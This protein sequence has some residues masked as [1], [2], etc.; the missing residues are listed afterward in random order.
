MGKQRSKKPTGRTIKLPRA[1]I[2][3]QLEAH[4][5][6]IA[7]SCRAYDA[8]FKDEAKR[9]AVSL[10]AICHETARSHSLLVQLDLI[11][12]MMFPNTATPVISWAEPGNP[13]KSVAPWGL[14][15]VGVKIVVG[16]GVEYEP[17]LG[18][19]SPPRI[20]PPVPFTSW[21]NNPVMRGGDVTWSRETLVLALANKD[22]GA[23]VDPE[24]D[25]DYYRLSRLNLL[26]V[27]Y[28]EAR[29][30]T[31]VPGNPAAAAVRQIAYELLIAFGREQLST[32]S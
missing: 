27:R 19:R 15:L 30:I 10:R 2:E 22:G 21:W 5:E 9:L 7:A 3:Q 20:N 17:P 24:L 29:G 23:H 1:E 11:K 25:E 16:T 18:R 4:L 6:F 28:I 13:A 31:D 8:G 32:G 14:G 12:T 26:G